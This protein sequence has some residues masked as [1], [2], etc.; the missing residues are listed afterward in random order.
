[1]NSPFLDA[2]KNFQKD[3][4]S[5]AQLTIFPSYSS[6]PQGL[7]D[8]AYLPPFGLCKLAFPLANQCKPTLTVAWWKTQGTFVRSFA[9]GSLFHEEAWF[10]VG[11]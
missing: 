2:R 9:M 1:M 11:L 6:V 3:P 8:V 4:F 7:I 5:C 10:S